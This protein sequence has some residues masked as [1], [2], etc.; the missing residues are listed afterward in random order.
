MANQ[1]NCPACNQTRF[2]AWP[3]PIVG[4]PG[5]RLV[6]YAACGAVVGVAPEDVDDRLKAI[7]AKLNA[8]LERTTDRP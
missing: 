1:P 7:E 5:V 8:I 4:A 6:A 3:T 2:T